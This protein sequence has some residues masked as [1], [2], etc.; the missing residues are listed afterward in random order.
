M[1]GDRFRIAASIAAAP[2]I[3]VKPPGHGWERK[4]A[5]HMFAA[6]AIETT[7]VPNRCKLVR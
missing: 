1:T 6:Q 7:D 3:V 4:G 2:R 5:G